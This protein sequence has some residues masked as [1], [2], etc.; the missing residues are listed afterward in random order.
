MRAVSLRTLGATSAELIEGLVEPGE[1]IAHGLQPAT[2]LYVEA[3]RRK[4]S[5]VPGVAE[6]PI[7]VRGGARRQVCVDL[8][9][10]R[11][12]VRSLIVRPLF[13]PTRS[14]EQGVHDRKPVAE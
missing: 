5:N 10:E 3:E 6:S 1:C 9:G 11:D 4:L 2:R 8:L 13:E 14:G 7:A 12:R